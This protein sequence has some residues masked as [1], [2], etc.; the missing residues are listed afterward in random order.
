VEV[1]TRLLERGEY[2]AALEL[3]NASYRAHP[4]ENHLRRLI[5]KAE[6]AYVEHVQ[7]QGLSYDR[8]PVPVPDED[9]SSLKGLGPQECF[10]MSLLNGEAD[11]RSILWV[12]PLREVDV[13]RTLRLMLD[14]RLIELRKTN[15]GETGGGV[16]DSPAV[17]E[18]TDSS[19]D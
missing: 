16:P 9:G 13:L 7:R 12:A 2:E 8:V 11:V 1:A 6:E 4:D 15:A 18:G 19:L 17:V 10:L 5:A 14:K 3:L